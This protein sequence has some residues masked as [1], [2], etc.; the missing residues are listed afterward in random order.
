MDTTN[1]TPIGSVTVPGGSVT[2][3]F[4]K[5]PAGHAIAA[6]YTEGTNYSSSTSASVTLAAFLN[7]GGASS[8]NIAPD[9]I[10]SLYSNGLAGSTSV[11]TTSQPPTT[12]GGVTVAIADSTGATRNA[13]LYLVSPTQ[14]NFIVP[15]TLPNGTITLSVAGSNANIIPITLSVA[16]IAPGLF[17]PGAQVLH[18]AADGSRTVE[19]VIGPIT[20]DPAPG[21][22][23]LILYGTGIRHN[24]DEANFGVAAVKATVGNLTLPVN[25]AGTQSQYPGLDQVQ[26]QLPATLK[27][28]GRVNLILTVDSQQTNAIPLQF[29]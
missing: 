20:L 21:G 18:L 14:I 19:T 10:V 7:A 2:L 13:A 16:S 9:E 23:Y 12:L 26:I 27:G 25:Y 4:A 6:V 24:S 8:G 15:A 22:T 5:V 17:N 29:Q 28:A 1:S 3:P 11:P